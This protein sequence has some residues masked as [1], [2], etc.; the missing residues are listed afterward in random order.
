MGRLVFPLVAQWYE[1][2]TTGEALIKNFIN[3]SL[4]DV[5]LKASKILVGTTD[6]AA[7]MNVFGQL[8]EDLGVLHVYCT[9]HL[10]NLTARLP[11]DEG[12]A[13]LGSDLVHS[14]EVAKAHVSFINKSPQALST[15]KQKQ[16]NLA[17]SNGKSAVV[18]LGVKADVVTRWWSTHD[19]IERLLILK[20]PIKMMTA[21]GKLG[22]KDNKNWES[23]IEDDWANLDL[24]MQLLK[25]FKE[26]QENLE[27]ETYLTGSWVVHCVGEVM[28]DLKKCQLP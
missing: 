27:G 1:G 10:C 9:D 14:L 11:F 2:N 15:L 13:A 22:A 4:K 12:N 23:L 20:D 18:P 7:N 26:V 24:I 28:E 8:L 5:K 21:E 16:V 3:M 25:P 19:M 17:H 6:T